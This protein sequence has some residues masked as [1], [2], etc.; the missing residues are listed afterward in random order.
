MNRIDQYFDPPADPLDDETPAQ[1]IA[2]MAGAA[3]A[4]YRQM[5]LAA[6]CGQPIDRREILYTASMAGKSPAVMI[7]DL[8]NAQAAY[9]NW[10]RSV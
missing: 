9:L 3:M 5:I 7:A 8:Q 10:Q 1:L 2:G 6:S 4:A